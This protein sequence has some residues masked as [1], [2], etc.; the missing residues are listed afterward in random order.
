VVRKQSWDEMPSFDISPAA[1]PPQ[2]FLRAFTSWSI[3]WF[4][5]PLAIVVLIA[6]LGVKING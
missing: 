5:A 1:M 6:V 4:Y 2:S 3:A